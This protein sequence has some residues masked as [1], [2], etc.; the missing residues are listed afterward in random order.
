MNHSLKIIAQKLDSQN[1]TL[2]VEGKR[3]SRY[4]IHYFHYKDIISSVR[5]AD[6][7]SEASI[8]EFDFYGGFST[9][10]DF[11]GWLDIVFENDPKQEFIRKEIVITLK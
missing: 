7:Y 9:A 3:D 11:V 2:L 8:A 5:G 6:Y 4:R 10:Q 1:V